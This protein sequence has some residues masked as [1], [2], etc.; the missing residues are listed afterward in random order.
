[1][2]GLAFCAF[3]ATAGGDTV[4][5]A[6]AVNATQTVTVQGLRTSAGHGAFRA[7]VF[8]QNGNL[9]VLLDQHDGIRVQ[10]LDPG[11]TTVL[12]QTQQGATG[13]AALAMSFDPAGNLYVTGTTSSSTL[14]GTSGVVFPT[15]ADNSTNSFVAK[16]DAN[17]N[18]IFLSFLGS[19]ATAAA[20]VAATADAVF[21][22]GIT[23]NPSFPVTAAGLQQSPASGSSE[24]GFVERFS[25]DGGTL[26]YATYLT[27]QNGN[28]VP[29]AIVADASDDAYVA[30]ATSSSGYPTFA[31]LVPQ[32]IGDT[33][34]TS[35]FL[36][37]LNP[38]GSLLAFSSFIPGAGITGMALDSATNTLLLAGNVAMGQFPV[39]TVA[40]PLTSASYQSMLRIPVDGQ[41]VMGSAVTVPGNAS[42]V[43]PG[44]AGSAWVSAA[45]TTPLFP[46]ATP[47][48]YGLGDS[49][50]LH[51]T[52]GYG[53]DQTLRFGGAPTANASYVTLTSAPGAP[54]VSGANVALPMVE[55]LTMSGTLVATEGFENPLAGTPNAALPS[56][57]RNAVTGAGCGTGQCT[58]S[59]GLLAVTETASSQASLALSVDSLPNLTLRNLGSAAASGIAI[60]ASGYTVSATSCGATLAP[61]GQCAIAL[62]GGGPGSVTVSA[63]GS[64][65]QTF[66]LSATTASKSPLA[67]S[68]YELDFGIVASSSSAAT[69]TLTVTNLTATPQSFPVKRDG[70]ASS[71]PYTLTA[72]SSDCAAGSPAG[73]YIVAA[74]ASCHIVFTL[75]ASTTGDVGVR[76]TWLAGTRD[77]VL[78]GWSQVGSLNLSAGEIDFGVQFAGAASIRLPRYLY[79]SNNGSTAIA[80]AM[81]GLPASSPFTVTDLCPTV[82]EA[83]TVC[84]I[85]I[86]Y[87]SST[88]PSDDTAT[89]NLDQGLSVQITGQTLPQQGTTGT[90][91]NPSLT[92]SPGTITFATPV[93]TTGFST[94]TQTVTVSNSGVVPLTLGISISGDFTMATSCGA[95][96][97][98]GGSC[99]A[100]ITFAPSQPGSRSGLLSIST[101]STF[102]PTDVAL[103]GTGL[104][105]LPANNGTLNLGQTYVGEP[106][107]AWY[108]VQQPLT[109]LTVASSS[110]Q[111]GVVLEPNT[112]SVPGNISPTAFA[113]TATGAC[114][115]C[116][117]GVRFLS[118]TAGAQ[119]GSLTM[120]TVAGGSPY[121]VALAATA[122][123]VQGMLL[124]P[125][126]EDFGPVA[127]NSSSAP[128]VFTLANLL[129][130]AATANVQT[131]I[132][133]GDFRVATNQAGG[134]ACS[135]ALAETA[136]C[137]VAVQFAPTSMGDRTGT[138][139]ITTDQGTVIASLT[140]FGLADPGLA[141]NPDALAFTNAPNSTAT[142]QAITLT[143]T[144][145]VSL[146]IGTPTA[147]DPSFSP[148]SHC[149]TLAT[150]ATCTITVTFVPQPA[151]VNAM[152]SIPVTSTVNGQTVTTS[153][154]V[155]LTGGYT[156]QQAGLELVPGQVNYG[157]AATGA[158]GSMRTFTLNNLTAKALVVSFTVPRD[159]PLDATAP[160]ATLAANASCSFAADY[161][162]M[163][164]GP[165][166]GTIFAN[167]TPTD[168]SV[169]V[170]ALSYLQ[171]YGTGGATLSLTGNLTPG[172][173]LNFGQVTSGQSTLQTLTVT[174]TG[175]GSLNVRRV[176]SQPPFL[177]TTTCGN[178]LAAGAT[179]TV[180]LTYAPIY[181]VATGSSAGPRNDAGMLTIESD[182]VSSPDVLALIGT[183][184]PI[185][186]PGPSSGAQVAAYSLSEQALTFPPTGI[187][188]A[189]ATQ[190]VTL[191]NTGTTLLSVN[192]IIAPADFTTTSGCATVLPGASCNLSVTFTPTTASTAAMRANAIEISTNATAALDFISVVGT[193]G[194]SQ[195]QLSPTTV[196][197]G[198]VDV[199]STG[200]ATVTVTNVGT[201]PV[202]F[203]GETA[204][205]GFT[206]SAGTCP[207]AGGSLA[208]G[209]SCTVSVSFTPTAAGMATGTM[210]LS[211]SAGSQPLTVQL[212]A[213]AAEAS[214]NVTPGALNF[215]TITVGA[216]GSL[217]L[218]V[219]DTGSAPLLNIASTI[220][221]SNAANFA[222]TAPCPA[223]LQPGTS[224]TLSVSFTPTSAGADSST[225]N[226]SSSAGSLP[227]TVQL[228]GNA[229][230]GTLAAA[231]AAL[232]FGSINVGSSGTVLLTMIDTGSA[233]VTNIAASVSGANASDFAVTTPCAGT[234]QPQASCTAVVSFLPSAA[235]ARTATLTITS[236]DP[237]GP[238]IIPLSGSGTG[239]ALGGSFVLT[240]GSGQT[241]ASATVASG[242]PAVFPL[243]LT[244]VNGFTGTVALTCTAVNPGQYATCSI[245]PSAL[246]ITG[247]TQPSTATI[248]TITKLAGMRSPGWVVGLTTVPVVGLLLLGGVR[249][250]RS[251][252]AALFLLSALGLGLMGC[253]GKAAPVTGGGGTGVLDTP[254]GAY[255][256]VVTA[257]STS[258]PTITSSVTLNLTVQ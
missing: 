161:L 22:T 14:T 243:T 70:G 228:T 79:L 248:N 131:V 185:T 188:N 41:S 229:I 181:E 233:P 6:Q 249:R 157:A 206:A 231:P 55:S 112:G 133:S 19:R 253:G 230:E 208:V 191:T 52:S 210:S 99:Q 223:A 187:G 69:Q 240:V 9:Y 109:T 227:L 115:G 38:A 11:A 4:A 57:M 221:G 35:G 67:L 96:L 159:F 30:G 51:L 33:G 257:T 176:V 182:A 90:S 53:F 246:T 8:G 156:T 162:P 154:P 244:P 238:T 174:N 211:S 62:G 10:E 168:G 111:F 193:A 235:G 87:S 65:S 149:A 84:Q 121:V 192:G 152:L 212:T 95:T 117:V 107:I 83:R 250:R 258:G 202:I 120:S 81:A 108:Q 92:V 134:A 123:P 242:S 189:S 220:S 60:T 130:A 58:A 151:P 138:L 34:A 163:T 184:G 254:A 119:T 141:L 88:A 128:V 54:A 24:N 142:Q 59:A 180:T 155:P 40:S 217:S 75:V 183:A 216:S 203:Y 28:T 29:A 209:A 110:S 179:C 178:A 137:F 190:T 256:Y 145:T 56:T 82:L 214:I 198:T 68:T 113:Q 45:L 43:T 167:G 160:C 72:S 39:A 132:A 104:P 170:Q 85:A 252:M 186:S 139:T 136:S 172:A 77:V 146:G 232:S 126:V 153:Y 48:D 13:D 100:L 66:A 204:T 140:G 105:L 73:T 25:A 44:P 94:S 78:T 158:P 12:A 21:V 23:F 122:M 64:G 36:T 93:V 129:A 37:K 61:S 194:T 150:G 197:F 49:G 144:G 5:T 42:F 226:L 143:N 32:M 116:Y 102:A 148:S 50:L 215:G 219:T 245:T 164:A 147:S 255:Q 199:G 200:T 224:C 89:L 26:V 125:I 205:T 15:R 222:V 91:A 225:L 80:H 177:G 175:T 135:G 165:L 218:T 97:A 1:M 3:L 7:A 74:S 101:G 236:S 207:P 76:Q 2:L 166:T 86:A 124:S 239:V 17:L 114:N 46:G 247:G 127:V 98:G 71:N 106:L 195:L 47:P 103:S 251:H 173:P 63:A 213:T 118:S 169:E 27:G 241:S 20:S 237:H 171:G 16:Y 196:Q 201:A 18:L 31:A 234:L